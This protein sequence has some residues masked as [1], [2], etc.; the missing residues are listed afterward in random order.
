[1]GWGQLSVIRNIYTAPLHVASVGEGASIA[2]M[3][4]QTARHWDQ[5]QSDRQ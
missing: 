3:V 1:M 4:Q 5:V 2:K